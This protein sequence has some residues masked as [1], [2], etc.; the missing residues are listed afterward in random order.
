MIRIKCKTP[1]CNNLTQ[2]GKYC[3]HCKEK[4]IK[5]GVSATAELASIAISEVMARPSAAS[6]IFGDKGSND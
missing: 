1:D 5:S 4:L 6:K 2:P 3:I